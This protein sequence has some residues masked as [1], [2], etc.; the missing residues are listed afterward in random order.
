MPRDLKTPLS[1]TTEPSFR[2]AFSSAKK[3]GKKTFNWKSKNY[4]TQ[5]A[6]EKGQKMI[7]KA[8]STFKST[9]STEGYQKFSKVA[10]R[11]NYNMHV[12]NGT[13]SKPLGKDLQKSTREINNSYDNIRM[14]GVEGGKKT[15][16]GRRK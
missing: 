2:T 3:S 14:N 1:K 13:E 10:Q 12:A 8:E 11:A 16:Y 9:G 15:K 6:E 4:T 7:N 5:T